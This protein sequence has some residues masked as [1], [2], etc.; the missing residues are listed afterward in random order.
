MMSRLVYVAVI[1]TCVSHL[2]VEALLELK[3]LGPRATNTR[4]WT[5]VRPNRGDAVTPKGLGRFRFRLNR[6]RRGPIGLRNIQPPGL[7]LGEPNI[8]FAP[9]CVPHTRPDKLRWRNSAIIPSSQT[10]TR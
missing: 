6:H 3:L 1:R 8:C 4:F 5:S 9:Y 7:T 10:T 2:F